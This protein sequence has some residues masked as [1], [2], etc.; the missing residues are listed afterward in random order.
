M[1]RYLS[2]VVVAEISALL[3][4]VGRHIIGRYDFYSSCS[5]GRVKHAVGRTQSV[6]MRTHLFAECALYFSYNESKTFN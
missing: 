1:L 2:V 3:L 5:I 4:L 6:P